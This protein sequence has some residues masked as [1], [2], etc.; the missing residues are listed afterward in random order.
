M[1]SITQ[2]FRAAS[3]VT[4]NPPQRVGC[5][6]GQPFSLLIYRQT[7]ALIGLSA[8]RHRLGAE[9][10]SQALHIFRVP[11]RFARATSELTAQRFKVLFFRRGST[12]FRTFVPGGIVLVSSIETEPVL[13][14]LST[15]ALIIAPIDYV[16]PSIYQSAIANALFVSDGGV[17]CRSSVGLS[18]ERSGTAY[19]TT[20]YDI[21]RHSVSR[22]PYRAQAHTSPLLAASTARSFPLP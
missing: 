5:P 2:W 7:C 6:P 20:T 4:K 13:P 10:R 11:G 1:T 9:G 12:A 14:T 18:A 19:A 3:Q 15:F 16:P 22:L 17:H 21:L 8:L